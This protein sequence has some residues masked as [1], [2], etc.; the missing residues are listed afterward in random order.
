MQVFG[1]RQTFWDMVFGLL[2]ARDK[3]LPVILLELIATVMINFTAG[4]SVSVFAFLF[5]ARCASALVQH[6]ADM[7]FVHNVL[8]KM[9][10]LH[11]TD[12]HPPQTVL[13]CEVLER[14]VDVTVSAEPTESV[15]HKRL[16]SVQCIVEKQDMKLKA[17]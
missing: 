6:T 10:V 17:G 14:N 1:R 3:S 5:Q 4:L 2:S 12:V 15:N 7:S 11:V 8:Y 13:L 9:H 16:C